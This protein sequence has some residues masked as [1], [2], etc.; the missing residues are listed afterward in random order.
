MNYLNSL[1]DS[2]LQLEKLMREIQSRA[3][4]MRVNMNE[5]NWGV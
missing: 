3:A 5:E 2:A 4:L 1:Y